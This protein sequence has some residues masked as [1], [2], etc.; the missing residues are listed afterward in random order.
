MPDLFSPLEA[1]DLS[2]AN[3]IVMAPLTRTRASADGVPTEVMVDHYAQRASVGLIISEG[4][5]PSPAGKGFDGQPG[6]V[7]APQL[8]GWRKVTDAVHAQ[9]GL[10]VAQVMHAGRA[11]H[12][13]ISGL[14][15]EAPSALAID[16]ETR[17]A[18]RKVAYPVPRALDTDELP[19]IVDSFVRGSQNAVDAGFDGVELHAANGYLLHEF[20]GAT[21]NVRT[22]AYG[23]TPENRIRLVVEVVEAVAARLGAGRVGIRISP[24]RNIQGLIENDPADVDAVYGGLMDALAPLGLAFV[25]V[26]HP[27]PA[28]ALVQ[29]LRSRFSGAFLVNTG[30]AEATTRDEALALMEDSLADAVVVGRAVIAN[31]DL[32]RRWKDEL[33]ENELDFSTLYADG[34]IG[35]TDYPTHDEAEALDRAA[36]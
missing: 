2:L 3:R 28:G 9:G 14:P 34:A 31:P 6:L 29:G 26:L 21:S 5:F 4:T 8:A 20:L 18:G 1:G 11:T 33:Q 7:T 16:G 13:D 24:E 25:S 17:A 10:I 22:D 30:F 15:V 32:V 23:G 12:P 19:G 27:E 36:S 35:Y